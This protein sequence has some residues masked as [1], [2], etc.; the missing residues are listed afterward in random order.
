MSKVWFKCNTVNLRVQDINCINSQ[1]KSWLYQDCYEKPSELALY[2]KAE[3]GGLGLFNVQLRAQALLIR[4]FME[5]A[6]NPNFRHS[7]F[8]QLLYR[9]HVL[10]EVTLP[11]PGLTPYYDRN[12]FNLIQHYL[13][14]CPMNVTTMTTKDW[15]KMLLEDKILMTEANPTPSLIPVR[16]ETLSPTTDWPLTWS[17]AR[18]RGLGSD[19][20]S[21]LFKLL[22]CLL[23]TQDRVARLGGAE[24]HGLCQLCHQEVEDPQHAFYFCQ[25]SSIAG[26]ALLGFVQSQVPALTPEASLRLE[27][28]NCLS[29]EERLA[30]VYMLS[31][32]L[33]FIWENRIQKKQ[34]HLHLMRSEIE[35][36]ISLLR[37]SR[38]RACADMILGMM[39]P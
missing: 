24:N 4:A 21:F 9:Y 7:L 5:T 29:D 33:K 12:F 20:T 14:N 23:P 37:K 27:F 13:S 10:G 22:H 18:T 32:G 36:Q 39:Q 3:D 15:Y 1:V 8:H 2:R 34:V 11:D 35:A 17:L 28:G 6:A 19:L 26:H 30:T 16:A 25:H 31:T 38:H